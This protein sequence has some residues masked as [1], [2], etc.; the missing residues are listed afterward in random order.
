MDYSKLN[1]AQLQ[2]AIR[3]A[4]EHLHSLEEDHLELLR[5][6]RDEIDSMRR[7][8]FERVLGRIVANSS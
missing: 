2:S 5:V 1:D 8:L 7:D 4:E 6:Y 3:F